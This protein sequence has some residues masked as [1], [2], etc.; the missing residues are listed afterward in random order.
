[1][2]GWVAW[3]DQ[4]DRSGPTYRTDLFAARLS[5]AARP[6]GLLGPVFVGP[7]FLRSLSL[8]LRSFADPAFAGLSDP[9]A[10]LGYLVC[11]FSGLFG[12]S[13]PGFF[14]PAVFVAAPA[15]RGP[16]GAFW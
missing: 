10:C 11:P 12:L 8:F 14:G 1:M 7:C 15:F 4:T 3:I 2:I 16:R 13:D 9:A 5:F 6:F